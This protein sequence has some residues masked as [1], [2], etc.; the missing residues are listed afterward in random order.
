MTEAMADPAGAPPPVTVTD[1]TPPFDSALERLQAGQSVMQSVTFDR[2]TVERFARLSGDGARVHN[3]ADFAADMGFEGPIV[4]GLLVGARFSRL[5]GMYLPGERSVIQTLQLNYR[6][7]VPIGATV[8]YRVEVGRVAASVGAVI[9]N[10]S[11]SDGD[12]SLVTGKSQCVF[13]GA[14]AEAGR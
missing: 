6:R 7:P 4:H 13:P 11:V 9:L 2:E 8:R 12:G 1:E 10:L 14:A 3:D 5:L